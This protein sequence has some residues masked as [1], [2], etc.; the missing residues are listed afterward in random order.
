MANLHAF[1]SVFAARRAQ[2]GDASTA[3]S[4]S[5]TRQRD[6][7][8]T[9]PHL[10]LAEATRGIVMRVRLSARFDTSEPPCRR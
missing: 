2:S 8:I 9:L 5:A 10:S 3:L 4:R 7:L 1:R 6:R